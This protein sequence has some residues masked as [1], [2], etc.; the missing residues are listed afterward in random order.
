MFTFSAADAAGAASP[1]IAATAN[2]LIVF[3]ID[4][5]LQLVSKRRTALSQKYCTP[6]VRDESNASAAEM[7]LQYSH[8]QAIDDA[9]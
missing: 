8:L 4:I 2:I 3:F 9:S 6:L 1:I 7:G 5:S